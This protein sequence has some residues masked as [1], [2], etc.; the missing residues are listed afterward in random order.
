[1]EFTMDWATFLKDNSASIFTLVGVFLGSA[2]T[3]LISFL[4]NRFE[5]KERDKDRE[6]KRKEARIQLSLELT[7]SDIKTLEDTIDNQLKALAEV[8]RI[9]TQHLVNNS[10]DT[11]M[12]SDIK[13]RFSSEDG[14]LWK[15]IETNRVSY[16]LAHAL[17]KEFYS[18]YSG[19]VKMY[20]DYINLLLS[21]VSDS[22]GL[23]ELN[24]KIYKTAGK[25]H[26]IMTEKLI[27]IRDI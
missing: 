24:S 19:F 25:L 2:I 14:K 7:K 21:S 18:E 26:T 22:Q 3:F 4:N 17:G 16:E 5:A 6:E 15:L 20:S 23:D 9:R 13:T 10:S 8:A 27:S 11:E 12:L 1:M